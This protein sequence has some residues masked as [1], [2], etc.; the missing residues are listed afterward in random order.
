MAKKTHSLQLA[1]KSASSCAGGG[2]C[3]AGNPADSADRSPGRLH[4]PPPA[5]DSHALAPAV[6]CDCGRVTQ[7]VTK[8][9]EPIRPMGPA[10]AGLCDLL[11]KKITLIEMCTIPKPCSGTVRC[12]V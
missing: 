8:Y 3:A 10:G 2:P 11:W 7:R 1:A 12:V 6:R 5:G 9:H 4:M